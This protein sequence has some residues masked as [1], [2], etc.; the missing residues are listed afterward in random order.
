[1]RIIGDLWIYGYYHCIWEKFERMGSWK[2]YKTFL[3][4]VCPGFYFIL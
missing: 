2:I 3:H 1:M 4:D